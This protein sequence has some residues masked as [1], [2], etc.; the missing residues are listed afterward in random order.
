MTEPQDAT[1]WAEIEESLGHLDAAEQYRAGHVAPFGPTGQET[2]AVALH[3]AGRGPRGEILH[4]LDRIE[5]DLARAKA[6]LR[7][8]TIVQVATTVA[9]VL[10]WRGR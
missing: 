5:H 9:L 10:M 4:Q 3:P 1:W 2:T 6:S 8:A 7:W